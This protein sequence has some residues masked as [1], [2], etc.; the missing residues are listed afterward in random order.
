MCSIIGYK[1]QLNVA[2][3]LVDSLK[4][5][6]YRGYDSVGIAII[7]NGKIIV[8][9][10]VGK[11]SNVTNQFDFGTMPGHA[12]IGHTRWATHGRVTNENAHPH[13]GCTNSVAI[14]HNGIIENHQELRKELIDLGHIFKSDTDSE[15][16]AHLFES[17]NAEQNNIKKTMIETCKRLKGTYAFVAAFE[18][19]SICGSRYDQPLIIGLVDNGYFMTSDVLGFLEYTDKAIFLDNR[20]IVIIDSKNLQIY[21]VDGNIV[22][23]AVTQVAWELA[24]IEKGKYAFH[25]LKEIHEQPVVVEKAG[26][27]NSDKIEEFCNILRN[28]ENVFLTASGTSYH[29]ALIAKYLLKNFAKIHSE[30]IVSS[31]FQYTF[32]GMDNSSV[33]L[34]LSQSGETADVMQAVKDAKQMGSKILSI[35]NSPTSSLAR[36]SDS[37]L[38][39]DCGPEIGVA[40]TKSFTAQLFL[41]YTIVDRLCNSSLGIET[42]RAPLIEALR[43]V[44]DVETEIE[45]IA[46]RLQDARD[47]YVLGRSIHYPIALEGALKIKELSYIHAEGIVAGELKHGPLALIDKNTYVI[48]INPD[49]RTFQDNIVSAREIKARGATIIGISNRPDDVYDI[50]IKIPFVKSSILYPIIEVVPLQILSYYLAL[51]KNTDPDYPRNLAKSVTVK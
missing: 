29:C 43:Q 18:D 10:G 3:L 45:G 26:S 6:E 8:K 49:D 50:F 35:V 22:N 20:D 4:R 13:Y 33:L 36:I 7:D 37:F 38:D 34:A 40:A 47:I 23:R 30:T 44:L 42:N 12:G 15:V 32:D 14:V 27:K 31:E 39:I 9:K 1:G 5:M 11:V 24:A 25:T 21:D 51:I 19:G 17:C 16:I 48:L 28:S 2:P 41:I 46:S